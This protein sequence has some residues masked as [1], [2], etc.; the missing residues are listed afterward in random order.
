MQWWIWLLIWLGLGAF[1]LVVLGL[2]GYALWTKVKLVLTELD[3]LTALLQRLEE[4]EGERGSQLASLE[5]RLAEAEARAN[6]RLIYAAGARRV[7]THRVT[8]RATLN[9]QR[10]EDS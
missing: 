2:I 5:E 9:R 10:L 1:A 3:R 6:R 7:H 4:A 8:G